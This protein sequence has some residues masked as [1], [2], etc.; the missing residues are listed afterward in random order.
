[1]FLWEQ[2]IYSVVG[3]KKIYITEFVLL[4]H[5]YCKYKNSEF[6][7]CLTDYVVQRG[8]LQFLGKKIDSLIDLQTKVR[9]LKGS[10]TPVF[11]ME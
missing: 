3:K 11:M 1:M 6:E 5:Q 7:F 9:T 10:T 4:P 8:T 2:L